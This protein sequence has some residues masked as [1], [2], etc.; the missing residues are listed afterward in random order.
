LGTIWELGVEGE[1][2]RNE[3]IENINV[4]NRDN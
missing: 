4:K 3:M 1:E 2:G